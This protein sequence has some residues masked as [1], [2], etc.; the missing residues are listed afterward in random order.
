MRIAACILTAVLTACA[1]GAPSD[2][3]GALAAGA[4][5]DAELL[6]RVAGFREAGF[7]RV[8]GP[9]PSS[10]AADMVEVWVDEASADAY[11]TVDPADDQAS[12]V[13]PD[14]TLIVKRHIDAAGADDGF[15]TMVRDE[16]RAGDAAG[17]Q[18]WWAR[19]SRDGELLTAGPVQF[20]IECHAP[21]AGAD[22]VFG[23]TP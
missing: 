8:A 7:R 23:V 21:R 2:D 12:A 22:F 19:A 6:A 13:F 15:T 20:C 4:P 1:P 17:E 10:H 5:T 16:R 3:A 11:L 14:G 9:H 18:W